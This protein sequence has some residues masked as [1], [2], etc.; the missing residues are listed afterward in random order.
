MAI[1]LNLLQ[2]QTSS[3]SMAQLAQVMNIKVNPETQQQLNNLN[4]PAGILASADKSPELI[5]EPPP[6]T[7]LPEPEQPIIPLLPVPKAT[8]EAEPT[9]MQSTFSVLLARLLKDQKQKQQAEEAQEPP[10]EKQQDETPKPRRPPSPAPIG[11][12]LTF[13]AD[14]SGS[15]HCSCL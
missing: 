3:V 5:E 10:E 15:M 12:N 11:M 13:M 4:L 14:I 7:A 8:P 9:T 2:S 6:S 1:L